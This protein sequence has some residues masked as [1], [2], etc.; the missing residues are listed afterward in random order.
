[1]FLAGDTQLD[2]MYM[3]DAI[4]AAIEVMEADP[5]RLRHRNAFNVTAMQLTPETLAAE[6]R[7]HIPDFEIEYDVDPVREAIAQSWPRR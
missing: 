1:C 4:R 5:E 7:K 2:M 6:I 3:P